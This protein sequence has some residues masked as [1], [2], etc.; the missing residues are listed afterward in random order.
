MKILLSAFACVPFAGSEGGVGWRYAVELGKNNQVVVI[1][2]VTRRAAIEAAL[3]KVDVPNVIFVYFR[4]CW[5]SPVPLNS[6]TAKLLFTAW[7]FSLLS[8]ARNLHRQYNFDVSWHLTYGV[9]RTPSFLGYIGIPFIFGPV[10]GGEDAPLRLKKS[11]RGLEKMK[12][13]VRSLANKFAMFNPFLWLALRKASLILVKTNETRRALPWPCR[14][15]AVTVQEI[16]ID[17]Q[18]ERNITFNQRKIDEPMELLYAGNLF[19]L[20]GVHLA[21]RATAEAFRR[22]VNL[23]LTIVGTGPIEKELKSLARDEGIQGLIDWMGRIPQRDLFEVY[24]TKHL[25]IFPSLHDSSGNVVLEAQSFGL[26]VICLD[27][28]GPPTLVD[29]GSAIVIQTGVKTERQ[30]ISALADAVQLLAVDEK[31]RLRLSEG[32]LRKA[33]T[34]TWSGRINQMVELIRAAI[35]RQ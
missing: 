15:K 1:T 13:L 20:K 2:D 31:M 4:P 8:F 10:G 26:P 21:I 19:G 7:Q 9:F 14:N 32:A 17:A 35:H 33:A 12:E 25:L 23:R 30:V 16:G 28:G 6:Y 22:G 27:L 29:K 11:I 24:R 5:L 3:A 34:Q 18:D